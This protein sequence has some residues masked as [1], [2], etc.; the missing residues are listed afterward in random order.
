[1]DRDTFKPVV[2][3]LTVIAAIHDLY[4]QKFAFNASDF[5]RLVGND[6]IR[7]DIEKGVPVSEMRRR[8]QKGLSRFEKVRQKY[9]LY[10]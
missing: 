10:K 1:M 6:W 8:W 9:L 4:P 2:V 7:Q 5:D 3:G